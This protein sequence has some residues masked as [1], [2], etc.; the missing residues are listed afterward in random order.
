MLKVFSL[1]V[2][3]VMMMFTLML[4][5]FFL[6]KKRIGGSDMGKA[7]SALEVNVFLPAVCF[8]TFSAHFTVE[9]MAEN[10]PFI[11]AGI[12]VAAGMLLLALPLSCLFAEKGYR[13]NL[14]RYSFLIPN[15]GYMGY[16]L[17]ESV[18]GETALFRMMIFA[19]PFNLVIYTYGMY[20]LNPDREWSLKKIV[21]PIM[22][23]IA[24]GMVFGLCGLRL[25]G[26]LDS[27]ANAAKNCMSPAAMILTGVVLGG[28][29]LKP[30]FTEG[31]AYAAAAIRG[32][33][34]PG[35]VLG[36]M[37]LLSVDR[38][39]I[40]VSVATVAM[41]FGLNSVVFPEAFGGDSTTGA[42]LCFISNLVSLLTIPAVFALLGRL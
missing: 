20:L 25:P 11:L 12:A 17:V 42:R 28:V 7:L 35:I 15:I 19:L 5:G 18:F 16:P 22:I 26:F 8:Q 3:Q 33:A 13:R 32:L 24:A 36:A 4:I 40:L 31:R 34:L 1:T 14:Y 2:S 23:S 37:L 41:P 6:R 39:I 10:A 9:T 30:I 38:E 29:P 21:N 27:A